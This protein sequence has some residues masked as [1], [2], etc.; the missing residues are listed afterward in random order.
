MKTLRKYFHYLF[1][2]HL[3]Y[4]TTNELIYFSLKLRLV[5]PMVCEAGQRFT[6]R[7]GD[8][9]LGTGVISKI[10]NNLS[11]EERIKLMEGKK[12]REKAAVKK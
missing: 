9:T 4:K 12:A 5:K 1:Y 10:N 6:L 7:L 2:F 11:E 8:L 3:I